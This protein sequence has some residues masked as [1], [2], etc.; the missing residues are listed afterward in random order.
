MS[1]RDSFKGIQ[2]SVSILRTSKSRPHTTTTTTAIPYEAASVSLPPGST[3]QYKQLS[4]AHE[5]PV[6]AMGGWM[7]E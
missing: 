3:E 4:A 6:E 2:L 5:F 1:S 7:D